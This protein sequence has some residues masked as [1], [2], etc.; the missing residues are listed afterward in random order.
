[1]CYLTCRT[2]ELKC[3]GYSL[4][5]GNIGTH[6]MPPALATSTLYP[7]SCFAM[8]TLFQDTWC[9]LFFIS[10]NYLQLYSLMYRYKPNSAMVILYSNGNLFIVIHC[11]C[12][13]FA[14]LLCNDNHI[15]DQ[16]SDTMPMMHVYIT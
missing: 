13:S 14:E 1:M 6:T 12:G 16:Y 10:C 15:T 9:L 5:M 2:N 11:F 8:S 3:I 4:C 7:V